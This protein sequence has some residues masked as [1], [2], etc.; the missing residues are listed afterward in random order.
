MKREY[1]N[2]T[3]LMKQFLTEHMQNSTTALILKGSCKMQAQHGEYLC[4]FLFNFLSLRI[5]AH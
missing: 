3:Q 5:L 1:E 2:K 4:T